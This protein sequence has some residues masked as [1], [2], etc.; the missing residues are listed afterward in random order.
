MLLVTILLMVYHILQRAP[1]TTPTSVNY[2]FTR[3]CNKSCSFCYHTAT[4]SHITALADAKRG[5]ALLKKAGMRKLNFAGGEPFLYPDYMGELILFCKKTLKLEAVSIVTNGSKATPSFFVKY[6]R[7]I[8]IIA[9]SCDSFDE[10]VNRKIGR[11]A[12]D[13]VKILHRVRDLCREYGIKFKINTV[14]LILNH[15][16][17]MNKQIEA[18]APFRWKC[19]Q[20]LSVDGENE[21]ETRLRDVRS[22]L[23]TDEQ[24]EAFCRRHAGQKCF[25]PEGNRVMKNSYLILDEYMRFLDRTGRGASGSILDVGVQEALGQVVWD[26]EAFRERGGVFDWGREGTGEETKCG[27]KREELE[28]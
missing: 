13:Q 24:F 1:T 4:T 2:H 23:I 7:Y 17:D 3:K 28:W 16:E 6:G 20:V 27:T 22:L 14:V 11:G 18:L 9:V 25:V 21:N 10:E 5:L 8:D 19:F 12:G 15:G 26:E